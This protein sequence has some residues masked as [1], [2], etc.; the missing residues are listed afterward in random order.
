VKNTGKWWSKAPTST[1]EVP[2]FK[3]RLRAEL[4]GRMQRRP[5]YFAPFCV[6]AA[7]SGVLAAALVLSVAQ[8]GW[9]L[10]RNDRLRAL[11]V[12]LRDAPDAGA[13]RPA[14]VAGGRA[15]VLEGVSGA[16]SFR[17]VA[18]VPRRHDAEN[19]AERATRSYRLANGTAVTFV[20]GEATL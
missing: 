20:S 8:P 14:A 6:S 13:S 16:W 7:L 1:V 9:P 18:Q 11:S 15:Y 17:W 19:P 12:A 3:A 2:R 4:V 5:T 10:R